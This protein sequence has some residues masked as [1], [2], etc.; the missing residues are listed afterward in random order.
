MPHLTGRGQDAASFCV[1]GMTHLQLVKVQSQV[2]TAKCSEP[3]VES[4]N[5]GMKEGASKTSE[6]TNRNLI[7]LNG[8]GGYRS[9]R[10]PKGKRRH[11]KTVNQEVVEERRRCVLPREI[12]RT[13][14]PRRFKTDMV[15]PVEKG[16][17]QEVS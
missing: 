8:G 1:S 9:N 15:K 2:F 17:P 7:R 16:L 10:N 11:T 3:Q 6:P 14:K 13:V 5:A 4:S 12:L